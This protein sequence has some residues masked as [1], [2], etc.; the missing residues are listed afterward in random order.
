MMPLCC[1]RVYNIFIYLGNIELYLILYPIKNKI[2]VCYQTSP[3][4][5]Y[6][7]ILD[8]YIHGLSYHPE[9]LGS[10]HIK[11]YQGWTNVVPLLDLEIL[12]WERDEVGGEG[13]KSLITS[14][15][16]RGLPLFRNQIGVEPAKFSISLLSVSN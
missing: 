12:E 8:S 2:F 1:F 3:C 10:R 13:L 9:L 6:F 15:G 7:F 11:L 5:R 16:H 14:I 4:S